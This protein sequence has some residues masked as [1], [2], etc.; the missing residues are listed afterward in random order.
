MVASITQAPDSY[1][2]L[3]TDGKTVFKLTRDDSQT[4]PF[5]NYAY[6][7]LLDKKFTEGGT[8]TWQIKLFVLSS[9]VDQLCADSDDGDYVQLIQQYRKPSQSSGN[10]N[11]FISDFALVNCYKKVNTPDVSKFE[12]KPGWNTITRT[13]Q[14]PADQVNQ[15]DADYCR[16]FVV[17]T[18]KSNR[19]YSMQFTDLKLERG[20]VATYWTPAP[21]DGDPRF[22]MAWTDIDQD[23]NKISMR[24]TKLTNDSMNSESLLLTSNEFRVDYN[25]EVVMSLKE[26]EA[27]FNVD[28]M[29]VN[30]HI[31]GDVVNTQN[32]DSYD[33]E[34]G[35]SGITELNKWIRSLGKTLNGNITINIQY[36][37]SGNIVLSGFKSAG[38][39]DYGIIINFGK[40]TVNGTEYTGWLNGSITCW[41]CDKVTVQSSDSSPSAPHIMPKTAEQ[42]GIDME[43]VGFANINNISVNMENATASSDLCCYRAA[44]GTHMYL[45]NCNAAG[46]GANLQ[47]V[48]SSYGYYA[49]TGSVMSISGCKGGGA[50]QWGFSSA[51]RARNGSIVH[52]HGATCPM[53]GF[54]TFNGDATINQGTSMTATSFWDTGTYPVYPDPPVEYTKSAQRNSTSQTYGTSL[55]SSAA[56]P[57][58]S[59]SLEGEF[60]T[61][62]TQTLVSAQNSD[63]SI[64]CG[65][66]TTGHWYGWW[67]FGNT[68]QTDISSTYAMSNISNAT[69]SLTRKTSGGTTA[70]NT[71]KVFWLKSAQSGAPSTKTAPSAYFDKSLYI[72]AYDFKP[73]EPK[74][75][76]LNA[77]QLSKL[78]NKSV[79]GIAVC[80]SGNNYLEFEQDSCDITLYFG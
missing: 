5:N 20:S 78:K 59:I 69:I 26:N 35:N 27:T 21:E 58:G 3:V 76:T 18:N 30:G 36:P 19:S 42:F 13:F 4:M 40:Q 29:K 2:K 22:A 74:I 17:Q 70:G 52:V 80:G 31:D 71:A 1:K 68:L 12:L 41:N 39:G 62:A 47:N 15:A 73:G 66:D 55:K 37:I 51:V 53:G 14:L 65:K 60:S 49:T 61:D 72:G 77:T 75:I 79:Y 6:C 57:T 56:P 32:T 46:C 64:R 24:A 25:N 63:G 34:Q 50:Q 11:T 54:T 43:N 23:M 16:F 48:K 38:N 10:N 45:V 28:T 7:K 33:V 8:Y 9:Y 44:R 67:Y